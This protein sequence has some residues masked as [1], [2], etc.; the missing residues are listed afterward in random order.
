M[1]RKFHFAAAV[2]IFA[3]SSYDLPGLFNFL[4]PT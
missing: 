2:P 4:F 3:A 1:S